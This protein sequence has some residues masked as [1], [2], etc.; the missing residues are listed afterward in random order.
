MAK[1]APKAASNIWL[2]AKI[3]PKAVMDTKGVA[4]MAQKRESGI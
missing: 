4:K 2:I 3:A 1:I